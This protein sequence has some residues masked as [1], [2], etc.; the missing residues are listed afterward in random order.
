MCHL[1]S[2]CFT[3]SSIAIVL[4]QTARLGQHIS[5]VRCV[6]SGNWN[7]QRLS[8]SI[9]HGL[10]MFEFVFRR[11]STKGGEACED[12]IGCPPLNGAAPS[13]T[14][15]SQ[16]L[17]QKRGRTGAIRFVFFFSS[18]VWTTLSDHLYHGRCV[19]LVDAFIIHLEGRQ[20][21]GT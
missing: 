18:L 6:V 4:H 21:V 13:W 17:I 1:C 12:S 9:L 3:T 10:Y 7:I 19:Y 8:A 2:S 16:I 20:A 15:H 5:S 11:L 14:K